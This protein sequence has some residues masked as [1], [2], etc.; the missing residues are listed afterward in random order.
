MQ[1]YR[2]FIFLLIVLCQPCGRCRAFTASN[3][4]LGGSLADTKLN[5]V[6]IA[7]GQMEQN[8]DII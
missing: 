4:N 6:E 2:H 8:Q 5:P 1:F 7:I 3:V